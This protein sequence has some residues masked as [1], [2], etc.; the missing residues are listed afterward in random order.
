MTESKYI[1]QFTPDGHSLDLL[2]SQAKA[3][4]RLEGCKLHDALDKIAQKYKF[5][6]WHEIQ[7][8]K[9]SPERD[10]FY[11][12]YYKRHVPEEVLKVSYEAYLHDTSQQ[13]SAEVFRKFVVAEYTR[14]LKAK[15][16]RPSFPSLDPEVLCKSGDAIL[17]ELSWRREHFGPSSLLPQCLPDELLAT[18]MHN[19]SVGVGITESRSDEEGSIAPILHNVVAFL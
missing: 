10:A 4:Q 17:K 19:Y 3:L 2:K 1:P 9:S 13:D 18:M 8:Q 14:F 7:R 12:S 15:D 6:N 16:D 11:Q 5:E